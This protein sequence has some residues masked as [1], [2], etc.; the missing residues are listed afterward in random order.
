MPICSLDR[1]FLLRVLGLSVV[2]VC[3]GV[4][5]SAAQI[6]VRSSLA[7]D[8]DVT[9][10]TT[11]EEIVEIENLTDEPT[12]ARLRL[13]DYR[14]T[15]EGT[16]EFAEPGE[17]PRSNATWVDVPQSVVTIPPNQTEAVAYEVRVPE[18]VDGAAPAGTYWSVLFV[19]P[20][21]AES[22]QSSLSSSSEPKFG[23]RQTTRYGVQIATHIHA[24]SAPDVEVVQT[25]LVRRGSTPHLVVDLK[26]TGTEMARPE[27][28]LEAYNESGR[29]ALQESAAPRRLYPST[30]VR[31]RLPLSELGSGQHEALV[32]VDTG[33]EQMAGYQ[34]SLEL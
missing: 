18:Q 32:L 29:V 13:R 3:A 6:A 12:Q 16:N 2:M 5:T 28:Q 22:P 27:V 7:Q 1:S 30:S 8:R 25:D 14:F 4:A 19:E 24:S 17:L 20:I 10:G 21:A 26:N 31:Y 9:P 33:G 23:V 15:S 11:Y 34:Y